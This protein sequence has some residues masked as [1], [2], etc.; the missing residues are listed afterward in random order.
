MNRDQVRR[1]VEL[2]NVLDEKGMQKEADGIDGI[3]KGQEDSGIEK[4]PSNIINPV[5]QD[6]NLAIDN[7]ANANEK[8]AD[9]KHEIEDNVIDNILGS[10]LGQ[11]D[12]CINLID[13]IRKQIVNVEHYFKK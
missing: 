3:V 6:L 7:L 1:L 5:T 11:V 4:E 9:M 2:A 8:L 10:L 12:A 13:S